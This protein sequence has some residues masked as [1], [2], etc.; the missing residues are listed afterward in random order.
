MGTVRTN[1]LQFVPVVGSIPTSYHMLNF[2]LNSF[3]IELVGL[4][5]TEVIDQLQ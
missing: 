3:I 5:D 1:Q 2:T 4:V